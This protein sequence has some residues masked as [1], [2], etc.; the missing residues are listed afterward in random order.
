MIRPV[1]NTQRLKNIFYQVFNSRDPFSPVAQEM[2]PIRVILFP[3]IVHHL[4][5]RQFQALL[6]AARK[7][8]DE[9]FYISML[10]F[11]PEE[12]NWDGSEFTHWECERP[13]IEEYR[14]SELYL[15][16]AMYSEN[17]TW[18]VITSHEC[19]GLLICQQPFW[20]VFQSY[21]PDWE[22]DATNFVNFWRSLERER[23][24]DIGW[25]QPFLDHLFPKPTLNQT[26]QD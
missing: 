4:E 19:H 9:K 21:Y 18:G 3:T 7:T 25:L 11:E 24:V 23:G 8:G 10:E 17:G 6:E 20:D 22:N 14:S 16:N 5:P 26:A 13:T 1:T 2:F 15:D 12:R